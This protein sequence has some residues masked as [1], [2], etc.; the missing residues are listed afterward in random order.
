MATA[1][2]RAF[3]GGRCSRDFDMLTRCAPGQQMITTWCAPGQQMITT[4]LDSNSY[5]ALRLDRIF[6]FFLGMN[7]PRII[8]ITSCNFEVRCFSSCMCCLS[9]CMWA[10]VLVNSCQRLKTEWKTTTD[11]PGDTLDTL[12]HGS[13]SLLHYYTSRRTCKTIS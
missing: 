4:F 13:G 6:R 9:S 11:G 3:G 10:L 12:N 7:D 2:N 8:S 5:I 1:V